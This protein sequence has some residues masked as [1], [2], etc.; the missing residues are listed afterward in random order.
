ML[1]ACLLLVMAGIGKVRRPM[2]TVGAL[3]SVGIAVP[4]G[5]VR[6]LGAGEALLA[7]AVVTVGGVAP[8]ALVAAAYLGFTGFLVIALRRGGAVSSCGCL[9]RPDTPPTRTHAVVT[10]GLALACAAAA[11]DGGFRRAD[12]SLTAPD[13]TV[14]AFAALAGW[15]AWL[16]FTVLPHARLPRTKEH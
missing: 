6:V 15:L 5:L 10:A 1:V 11:A 8:T 16:A 9:S 13:L 3:R 2:P 14:L 7:L 12:V 4:R